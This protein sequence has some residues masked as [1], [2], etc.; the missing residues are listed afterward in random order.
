MANN[1]T[2]VKGAVVTTFSLDATPDG[3]G[4]IGDVQNGTSGA[5]AYAFDNTIGG[6]SVGDK[7]FTGFG[8]NDSLLARAEIFDGNND[9][10]IVLGANAR[11]DVERSSATKTGS[12]QFNMIN[13]AGESIYAVRE[14]GSKTTSVGEDASFVYADASTRVELINAFNSGANGP[15]GQ[16]NGLQVNVIEGTVGDDILAATAGVDYFLYDTALG[17]NLG[18]DVITG[19]GLGDRIVTTSEIWNQDL[20]PFITFGGNRILD[21]PGAEGGI[22]SD[23]STNPGGQIDFNAPNDL[24]LA[25]LGSQLIAGHTYYFYEYVA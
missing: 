18:G 21:L 19:F 7:T 11:L 3:T 4:D 15:L 14:L 23:P 2:L 13:E 17:L 12:A 8:F 10:Y 22:S 16:S 6:L 25:I 5:D 1:N 24:N 9:G 20:D